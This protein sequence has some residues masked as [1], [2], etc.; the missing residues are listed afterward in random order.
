[1]SYGEYDSYRGK[2]SRLYK[3]RENAIIMGVCSGLADY[4]DTSLAV[5]RILALVL[6]YFLFVPTV[7]IYVTLG[8]LLKDKP[9]IFRGS[10]SESGFWA[11]HDHHD[12]VGR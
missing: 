6:L 4:F 8:L 11:R 7:L 2:S 9:L 1:M 3:D 10:R 5:T 12:T